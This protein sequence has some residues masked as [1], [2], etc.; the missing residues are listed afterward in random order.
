MAR[1]TGP[2]SRINR[3]FNEAI[4]PNTKNMERKGYPPGQHGPR[5]RRKATEYSIGLVEKQ[6][7]KYFYG[8]QERP[9]RN[10]FEKAKQMR[11]VTGETFLQMLECR[12]DSVIYLLGFARTRRQARQM[13]CH[14]HV[15]VNDHKLDI[16]SA[17]VRPGDVVEV[18]A[19][20]ASRQMATRALEDNRMRPV[21]NWLSRV[22]EAL[23]GVMSRLPSR[24]EIQAPVNEQLIVEFYSR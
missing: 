21:P 10:A 24:E 17:L 7:L 19:G 20:T 12:L 18:R 22:D 23:R 14:G 16:P 2:T 15:R 1:Y 13:V 8:L 5:L 9:F 6:K 3:R 11:G 4:F